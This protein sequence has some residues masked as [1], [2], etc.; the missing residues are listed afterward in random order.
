MED[1][2]VIDTKINNVMST[3][4][5]RFHKLQSCLSNSNFPNESD[6]I[7][8]NVINMHDIDLITDLLRSRYKLIKIK[9]EIGDDY[10]R[11]S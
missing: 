3:M 1:L 5:D 11:T 6:I 2:E 8:F 10:K 4:E 9:K 7:R